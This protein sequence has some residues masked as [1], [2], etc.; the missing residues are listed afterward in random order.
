MKMGITNTNQYCM[1]HVWLN[2]P[3]YIKSSTQLRYKLFY[4]R[5]PGQF[6]VNIYSQKFSM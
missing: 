4:V 6:T 5:T 3:T 1:R 2:G